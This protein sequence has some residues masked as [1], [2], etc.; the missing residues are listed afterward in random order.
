MREKKL[1]EERMKAEAAKANEQNKNMQQ[2]MRMGGGSSQG[3][4]GSVSPNQGSRMQI[5]EKPEKKVDARMNTSDSV[6]VKTQ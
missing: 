3:T 6:K 5:Q 1:A 4:R 2:F